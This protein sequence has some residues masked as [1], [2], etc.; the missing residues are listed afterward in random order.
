M[1][2]VAVAVSGEIRIRSRS[3]VAKIEAEFDER[4]ARHAHNRDVTID[5][6]CRHNA[7]H[8][9]GEALAITFQGFRTD[10]LRAELI[11]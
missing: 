1:A 10:S 7:V 4:L 6:H 3:T 8:W 11:D 2:V 5:E 9:R